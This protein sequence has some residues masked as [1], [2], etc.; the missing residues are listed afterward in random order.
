MDTVLKVEDLNKHLNG[1]K[2]SNINL[3]LGKGK[4]VLLA[5]RNGAGKTKLLET[6]SCIS[7]PTNGHIQFF[8]DTIFKNKVYKKNLQNNLKKVGL[9]LQNERLFGSLTVEEIFETFSSLYNVQDYRQYFSECDL[10]KE[11]L[12]KRIDKL[13]EGKKQLTKFLL[14][15][16]HDPDLVLLDEPSTYLD[17]E[18]RKW[19]F[20]KV[21][22]MKEQGKSF[23]ISTNQIWEVGRICDE[24]IILENG[25]I[26]DT[27]SE[28]K[29]YYKG[30]VI[31]V[32]KSTMDIN[33]IS[34][35]ISIKEK[36][37]K[38]VIFTTYD[39]KDI[40]DQVELEEEEI[41]EIRKVRLEDFYNLK[42]EV[43]T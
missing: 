36:E 32:P 17:D 3:Y 13:S 20:K 18:V 24:L 43:S 26:I 30:S 34:G 33:S 31:E 42:T 11:S 10:I 37:N 35:H 6:I 8:N 1:F 5:G 16:S 25:K 29:K 39:I 41:I 12:D 38:K 9:M 22:E 27:I 7:P 40:L 23:L 21:R 2:L 4:I 14:S 15:I 28:F 19:L